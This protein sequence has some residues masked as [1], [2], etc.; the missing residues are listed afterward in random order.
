[1]RFK[2][3]PATIINGTKIPLI[4]G[5]RDAAT[6]DPAQIKLWQ[7]LFRDRLKMFGIP[8]GTIN[9]IMVLDIDVVSENNPIS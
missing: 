6:S 7:E 5:W 1:M 8:C 9:G 3:F 2:V 4:K